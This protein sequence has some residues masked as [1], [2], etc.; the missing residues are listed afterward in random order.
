[1][2]SRVRIPP[3]L[4]FAKSP[5]P[6][7]VAGFLLLRIRPSGTCSQLYLG[8]FRLT[9]LYKIVFSDRSEK[10]KTSVTFVFLKDI[11]TVG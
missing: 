5:L 4:P 6:T 1:M 11:S 8:L 2:V 9:Y 10:V 7:T 3:G